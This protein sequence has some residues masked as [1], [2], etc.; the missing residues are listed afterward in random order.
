MGALLSGRSTES[1]LPAALAA[2]VAF[3]PGPA[4]SVSAPHRDA[5]RLAFGAVGPPELAEGA[6][7]LRRAHLAVAAPA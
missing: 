1:L 6:R 7:R 2:G 3:V 4:F 5:L